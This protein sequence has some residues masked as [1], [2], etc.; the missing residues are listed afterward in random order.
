MSEKG[1]N[2]KWLAS[3]DHFIGLSEEHRP[4]VEAERLGGLEVDRQLDLG[5]P[6][7]GCPATAYLWLLGL[8]II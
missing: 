6:Q 7:E 1:Q 3:F 4:H 8:G 5:R 2:R